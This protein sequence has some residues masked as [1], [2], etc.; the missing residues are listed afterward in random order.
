MQPPPPPVAGDARPADVAARM[1]AENRVALAV[2]DADGV[3]IG[4][5]G[6]RALE[7]VLTSGD[8]TTALELTEAI[9]DLHPGDDLG[10]A[11]D[12]LADGDREA[13]PVLDAAGA[14]AG[15]IEHRD[16][17]RAYAATAPPKTAGAPLPAAPIQS[18]ISPELRVGA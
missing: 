4:V 10:R 17:L 12:W 1:A 15:W 9:P 8:D 11:I 2:I 16:V 13:L 18:D 3:V 7:R 6:A 5:L 14:L